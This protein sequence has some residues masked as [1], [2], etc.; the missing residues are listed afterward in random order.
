MHLETGQ[1]CAKTDMKAAAERQMMAQ[2]R[3]GVVERLRIGEYGRV[4]VCRSKHDEHLVA[5]I[6]RNSCEIVVLGDGAE[7]PLSRAREA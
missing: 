6:D 7:D 3:T 4:A 5:R 2:T 1:R